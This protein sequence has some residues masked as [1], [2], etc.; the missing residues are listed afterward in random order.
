MA[1]CWSLA[2]DA[3]FRQVGSSSGKHHAPEFS[4]KTTREL[5]R[6]V[7]QLNAA[8]KELRDGTE[9]TRVQRAAAVICTTPHKDMAHRRQMLQDIRQRGSNG[10]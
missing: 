4:N 7:K 3:A 8:A 6:H 9:G 5:L 1:E 10:R 2:Y